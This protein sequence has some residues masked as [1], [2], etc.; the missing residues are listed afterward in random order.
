MADYD[1][2]GLKQNKAGQT[3]EKSSK[4]VVGS[5]LYR[6]PNGTEMITIED[7]LFGNAQGEAAV[8]LG[9]E[10]IRPAKPGEVKSIIELQKG[11][12]QSLD[13]VSQAKEDKERL[14]QLELAELRRE[15][16]EREEAEAQAAADEKAKK[17]EE[18][19]A[20]KAEAEAKKAA[21]TDDSEKTD[22]SK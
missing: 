2:E 15:R 4:E 5:G 8:R 1:V 21:K 7:P 17:A 9:F 12:G 3:R 20:K 19:A 10:F 11:E 14:D 13:A 18:K 22:E 6:H 16:R